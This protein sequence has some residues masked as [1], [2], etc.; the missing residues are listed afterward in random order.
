MELQ[1][2]KKISNE[3]YYNEQ[4]HYAQKVLIGDR[5]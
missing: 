2:Y 1:I 3:P 4:A 5:P